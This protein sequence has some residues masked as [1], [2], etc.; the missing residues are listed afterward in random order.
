MIQKE[1]EVLRALAL[2]PNM[3]QRDYSEFLGV[4]LGTVNKRL[5]SLDEAGLIAQNSITDAGWKELEQHKVDNAIVMAAGMG[6]RLAPLTFEKPKGLFKVRGEVL[7]ERHL[8]QLKDA[9]IDDIYLVVGYLKEQF[10]Y[11][12]EEYGVH[13]LVNDDYW[14]WNNISTLR[15]ARSHLKNSYICS[16]DDWMEVNPYSRWEW[17]PFYSAVKMD[18]KTDEYVIKAKR[19]GDIDAVLTNGGKDCWCMYGSV[20]FTNEFSQSFLSLIDREWESRRTKGMLWE[21]LYSEHVSE[22]PSMQIKRVYDGLYEFDSLEDL[23]K[24]DPLYVDNID[25]SILSN[26]CNVFNIKQ[27][28]IFK[29]A[30]V[31]EGLT[32]NS[33]SFFTN[34]GQWIYRSPGRGTSQY[35]NRINEAKAVDIAVSL[36]LD[37]TVVHMDPAEGWKISRFKPN[38]RQLDYHNESDIDE[39]IRMMHVLHD[40]KMKVDWTFGTW[41]S[42]EDFYQK[43]IDGRSNLPLDLEFMY[44]KMKKVA[45][46]WKSDEVEQI[47]CHCDCYAPN[48][49]I[50]DDGMDLIDWE[51]SGMDDP[52][53]DLGTFICCSDMTDEEIK[54]VILKYYGSDISPAVARHQSASTAISAWYWYVWALW[55]ESI[56]K[57][58]GEWLYLWWKMA[59][60]WMAKSLKEYGKEA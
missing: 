2:K 55:Q 8:R 60:E 48:F 42:S 25:S 11:L 56:G 54:T 28:Q 35:I 46:C 58:T 26:I 52:A 47:L 6:T 43:L 31:K 18:G 4:S 24:F 29:M 34:D 14:R 1:F 44:A 23:R 10:L 19:N 45:S 20:Y 21:D 3:T 41:D 51:Y 30:P 40:A 59:N 36:K 49:L 15:V 57:S 22:L 12:E 5:K 13:I 7:I 16:S 9:G 37:R 53:C 39:A 38:V 50:G 17:K 33:F 27:S 32:N